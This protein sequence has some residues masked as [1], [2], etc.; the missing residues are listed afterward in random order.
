[1]SLAFENRNKSKQEHSF[2]LKLLVV[3]LIL[4]LLTIL[5]ASGNSFYINHLMRSEVQADLNTSNLGSQIA[6]IDTILANTLERFVTTGDTKW[7]T[8]YEDNIRLLNDTDERLKTAASDLNA[9]GN[10][11]GN[12]I[13]Q[14]AQRID[15]N[16]DF[17]LRASEQKAID[18]ASTG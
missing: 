14:L 18:L 3:S 4:T 2:P 16:T 15:T 17:F 7:K 12:I 1:F 11:K 8:L 5:W 6:Y 10:I 13:Y 9:S